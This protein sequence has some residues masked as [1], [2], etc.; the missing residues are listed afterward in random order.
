MASC[1]SLVAMTIISVVLLSP[2]SAEGRLKSLDTPHNGDLDAPAR[3]VRREAGKGG[4]KSKKASWRTRTKGKKEQNQN[5]RKN[6]KNRNRKTRKNGN[7]NNNKTKK[8]WR[9]NYH[10]NTKKTVKITKQENGLNKIQSATRKEEKFDHC[11]YL[12]LMEVGTRRAECGPGG[13]FIFKVDFHSHPSSSLK[14]SCPD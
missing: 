11:D 10:R 14:L 2:G 7:R 8:S 9:K 4:R 12:D 5:A 13:K 6:K 1:I 3:Q